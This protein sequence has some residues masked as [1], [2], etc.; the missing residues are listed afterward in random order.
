VEVVEDMSDQLVRARSSRASIGVGVLA[1]VATFAFLIPGAG[2]GYDQDS[3]LTV[4]IFVATRSIWDAFDKAYLLTNQVLFS[5]LDH[6]VYS[7]TGSNNEVALRLLPITLS[8]VAVGLL[9]G[10]MTERFGVVP[11]LA[12]AAVLA[13]NPLFAVEGSQVRGYSLVVVCAIVTTMLFLRALA[14]DRMSRRAR[15]GYAVVG[16]IGVATHLYMLIVLGILA[17]M[18]LTSRRQFERIA[19]PSLAALLGVAAYIRIAD[20]MR[21]VIEVAGRSFQP[22][23]P[24]DLSVELLGGG[25]AATIVTLAIVTPVAWNAR[26]SRVVQLAAGAVLGAVTVIWLMG[27]RFL[28]PRF[29]LWLSPA[30]AVAV[31]VAVAKRPIAVAL[32]L[33]VVGLQVHTAW[34]RL[35]TDVYPNR[36]AG[37]IFNT[38][39]EHGGIACAIDEYTGQRLIGYTTQFFVLQSVNAS[40]QCTVIFGI[41]LPS[42]QIERSF[43]RAFPYHERL[44]AQTPGVL[45]S[46][47][48]IT[49]WTSKTA[50]SDCTLPDRARTHP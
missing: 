37:R 5:F 13:T 15:V 18:S 40:G 50:P 48:P 25:I 24:R 30:V 29:F 21:S 49:C 22:T 31:A 17:V 23:F 9:A 16:A 36:Q 39:R 26:R 11:G 20:T 12:S 2:R 34:P 47:R 42:A 8:A 10:L 32:V 44:K 7:A 4:G 27:P 43:D 45:W 6:L 35:T 3:G 28:Y 46:A 14:T 41:G 19:V 1:A 33:V 38:V